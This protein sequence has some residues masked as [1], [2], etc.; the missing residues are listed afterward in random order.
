[1]GLLLV[2]LV[3]V[4]AIWV[5]ARRR[6]A[7]VDGWIGAAFQTWAKGLDGVE[8]ETADEGWRVTATRATG[9]RIPTHGVL[10]A[11]RRAERAGERAPDE[12]WS[13]LLAWL[14]GPLPPLE[15]PFHLKAHGPRVLPRLCHPELFHWLPAEPRP[16]WR[17]S[18]LSPLGTLYL[19]VEDGS[20]SRLI[21]EEALREAGV[22]GRDLEGIALAVLR[23]R[24][25]EET[26]RRALAGELVEIRPADGC[27]ASRVLVAGD[28][29]AAGQRLIACVPSPD[30]LLMTSPAAGA[31]L[32]ELAGRRGARQE[33]LSRRLL[34]IDARGPRWAEAS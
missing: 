2:A 27:G 7:E 18:A 31:S 6:R 20:P 32:L 8:I 5:R 30:R 15:G 1:M 21:T 11:A 3:A 10:A 17:P 14:E 16:S 4:A 9:V 23:Q 26:L 19:L 28:F 25:E 24:F 13:V 12:R 33:P 29:L 34:E 22:D